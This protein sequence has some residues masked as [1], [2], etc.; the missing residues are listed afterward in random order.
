MHT[1]PLAF[2]CSPLF[3]FLAHTWVTQGSLLS[4]QGSLLAVFGGPYVMLRIKH[5]QDKNLNSCTNY[6]WLSML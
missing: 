4:A 3:L 6:I 5:G 1:A 2:L